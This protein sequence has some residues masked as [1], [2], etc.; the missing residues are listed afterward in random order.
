MRHR[1][2][3]LKVIETEGG[4]RGGDGR[5]GGSRSKQLIIRVCHVLQ[6]IDVIIGPILMSLRQL[7]RYTPQGYS[8]VLPATLICLSRHWS[9]L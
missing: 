7:S 1:K 3:I 9:Y 2:R 5:G 4:G 8:P 6:F